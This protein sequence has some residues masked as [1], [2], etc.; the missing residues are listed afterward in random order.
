MLGQIGSFPEHET[1]GKHGEN[2]CK[3]IKAAET[4]ETT[5]TEIGVGRGFLSRD[6]P[7]IANNQFLK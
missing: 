7:G 2:C 6:T 3:R 5:E 4:Q 1:D